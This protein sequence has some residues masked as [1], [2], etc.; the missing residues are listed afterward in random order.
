M[1]I[2]NVK[3][4]MVGLYLY[5]SHLICAAVSISWRSVPSVIGNFIYIH[6]KLLAH[7][8]THSGYG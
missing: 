1:D 8:D 6:S 3:M 5:R 7:A 2:M 4:Q